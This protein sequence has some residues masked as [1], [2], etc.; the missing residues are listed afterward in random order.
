MHS[1]ADVKVNL[2]YCTESKPKNN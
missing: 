1:K 2:I